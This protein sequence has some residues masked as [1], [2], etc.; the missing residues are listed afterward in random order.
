MNRCGSATTTATRTLAAAPSTTSPSAAAFPNAIVGDTEPFPAV[1]A[2]PNWAAGFA[3]WTQTFHRA[4]GTQLAFLQLDFNWGD[5]KLNTGSTH[6]GSNAAAIAALARQVAAVA[7]QNGL[8]VGMIY[9]GGGASDAQWMDR[10]RL[11]I[12][13]VAA[14]GVNL[15]Q[16]VFVSWNPY[17]ARTFPASDPTALT[18]L[19]PYDVQHDR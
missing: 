3:A 1:S 16:A 4:T 18:N 8:K 6:D 9:W 17:P 19:I 12:R 10:A 13:E 14:A 2:Q 7:R 5:P 11:L 15:D